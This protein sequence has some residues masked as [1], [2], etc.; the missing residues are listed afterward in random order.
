MVNTRENTEL[1]P[2]LCEDQ[3]VNYDELQHALDMKDDR[4]K[5]IDTINAAVA[6]KLSRDKIAKL[7]VRPSEIEARRRVKAVIEN[8]LLQIAAM[9]IPEITPAQ[10]QLTE[11]QETTLIELLLQLQTQEG[12]QSPL[13]NLVTIHEVSARTGLRSEQITRALKA[14]FRLGEY[15]VWGSVIRPEVNPKRTIRASV[16]GTDHGKILFH[17]SLPDNQTRLEAARAYIQLL[18]M[19]MS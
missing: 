14:S 10:H 1:D 15:R 5:R 7:F 8:T 9:A 11:S 2:V 12:A 4:R 3:G 6:G 16:H 19:R 13:M 17:S 18:A